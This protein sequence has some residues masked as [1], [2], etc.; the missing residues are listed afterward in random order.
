M[1]SFKAPLLY[2]IAALP[3]SSSID[4]VLPQEV[5]EKIYFGAIYSQ[6]VFTKELVSDQEENDVTAWTDGIR[7]QSLVAKKND[8][9]YAAFCSSSL[10]IFGPL[11]FMQAV[12]ITPIEYQGCT[13][14]RGFFE[15]YHAPYINEFS[16]TLDNCLNSCLAETGSPCELVLTGHSQG[17]AAAI[18]ASLNYSSGYNTTVVTFG[19][20]TTVERP[21]EKIQEENHY[22][23][24]NSIVVKNDVFN[25]V[26][27]DIVPTLPSLNAVHFGYTF[28]LSADNFPLAYVGMNDMQLRVPTD[29]WGTH[30]MTLYLERVE[31]LYLKNSDIPGTGWGE[32]HLCGY[33]DECADGM[34]CIGGVFKESSCVVAEHT[35]CIRCYSDEDCGFNQSCLSRYAQAICVNDKGEGGND[36]DCTSNYECKSGRCALSLESYFN[37]KFIPVCAEMLP[38]GS[39]CIF[40]YDC[41]SGFCN[42]F[43]CGEKLPTGNACVFS[44]DCESDFCNKF[45]CEEKLQKGST[46]IF[47]SDCVSGKCTRRFFR[48]N[49]T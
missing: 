42:K 9:C 10:E 23:F 15:A 43:E 35:K 41:V 28:V 45:E 46:C 5:V 20:P 16:V 34:K 25:E 3:F 27:Y 30:E 44:S 49:C 21:C 2:L 26:V 31:V 29:V 36:C 14:R 48:G 17:G 11:D 19:A 37:A 18:A 13:T 38:L 32:G 40:G 1:D 6:L 22:R 33:N 47:N 39:E 7:D 12:D 4:Y 8:V 24:I